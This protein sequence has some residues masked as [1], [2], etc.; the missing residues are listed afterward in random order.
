MSAAPAVRRALPFALLVVAVVV[1]AL[2]AGP[3]SQGA[4]LDPRSTGPAGARAVVD[5]LTEL[6]TEVVVE[7][8]A[9][10]GLDR[11]LLL[12]DG[13]DDA[14]R[15]D[16]EAWVGAGGLL[17]VADPRSPL[18][19]EAVGTA[20][21][22]GIGIAPIEPDCAIPAL[23]DV[24]QVL[25]DRNGALYEAD[26]DAVGCFP[27]GEGFWLVAT[28]VGEGAIVALGGPGVL[29]NGN[30]EQP[31]HPELLAG[32]L[33]G[34]GAVGFLRPQL[35]GE[36]DAALADLIGDN[37][38]LFAVQLLL[39]LLLVVAWRARRL[40]SPVEEPQPVAIPGSELVTA[41]GN[42]LQE[43]GSRGRAAALLRDDLR[44]TLLG[45]L[46]LPR[47]TPADVLAETA[48]ARSGVEA[49]AL[50]RALDPTDP[51]D[52]DALV[53]LAHDIER[54]RADALTAPTRRTP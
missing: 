3:G 46:G 54:L 34:D 26:G 53:A 41:V 38:R 24:A 1:A 20:A 23:A 40:G 13:L 42:L 30:L 17:V 39:A 44:R 2:V 21:V 5:V 14:A 50:R 25:P 29:V 32:L 9:L 4:P 15:E 8:D 16:L 52:A 45:R 10:D 47:D 33:A 22:G 27:R 6:G 49:D 31:G 37:V 12:A 35:P 43:G 11:A 7:P 19:P 51:A 28:P 48:A 18:T 36:G